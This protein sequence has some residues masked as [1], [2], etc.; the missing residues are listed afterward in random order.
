MFTKKLYVADTHFCHANVI[1]LCKRPFSS[2]DEMDS[3]LIRRWNDAV[4]END[5]VY[6][7]GD[8]AHRADPGRVSAIFHALHGRKI[9]IAGNHDYD[10]KGRLLKVHES[11]PWEDIRDALLVRDEGQLVYLHHYACRVWP[12]SHH[13]AWHFYGHSH[14]SLPGFGKSRDIGVDVP[15]VDFTPRTFKEL[16]KKK[17]H[18]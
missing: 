4:G 12:H 18:V 13:E 17:N 10:R 3:A 8:F 6:H 11:L 16:T 14:G 2:A 9:L 15:D 7:L 5:L 1:P